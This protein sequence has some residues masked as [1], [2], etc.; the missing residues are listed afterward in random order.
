MKVIA[1]LLLAIAGKRLLVDGTNLNTSNRRFRGMV[2]V[3]PAVVATVWNRLPDNL[4]SSACPRH[5]LWCLHFLKS[6]STENVNSFI[7][8][9]DEEI[10]EVMLVFY[11]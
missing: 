8:N 1:R 5:L 3:S 10:Q 4:I 6:Y 11:P 2:G 7:W 9:C